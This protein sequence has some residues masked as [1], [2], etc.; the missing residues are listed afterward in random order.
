MPLAGLILVGSIPG[1]FFLRFGNTAIIKV[2][3]GVT[4]CGIGVEM[5]CR[6]KNDKTVAANRYILFVIGLV[7]GFVSGLFGIGA[8]LAAYMG[9]ITKDNHSF[10]GNLRMVFLTDNIFRLVVYICLRIIT[11]QVVKTAVILIPFMLLGLGVGALTRNYLDE[12]KVKFCIVFMLVFSGI[13]LI[14]TNI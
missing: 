6:E 9:R 2:I 11:F 1:M 5:F 10:R 4:V 3:L 7:A 14:L 13:S 8:L 12:K